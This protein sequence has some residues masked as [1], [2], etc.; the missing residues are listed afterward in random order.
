ML[1][2]KETM[3]H[4]N[5][6]RRPRWSLS[7]ALLGLLGLLSS[8]CVGAIEGSL[9]EEPQR[10]DAQPEIVNPSG[11]VFGTLTAMPP[12]HTVL[13]TYDGVSAY[14][15]GS[16]TST[17]YSCGGTVATGYQYQCVELVQRY[18]KTKWGLRWYGNAK[19]LLDNAPRDATDV[20]A[21]GD[22]A[23]PPVPGDMIVWKTGTWGHVALVVAVRSDA[24]DIIEQNVKGN[25][26]AT[27][28]YGGGW[29]QT[30][31]GNWDVAGWVHAKANTGNAAPAPTP[32][33]P[34]PP[35]PT[36]PTPTPPTPTS[37]HTGAVFGWSFCSQ[38]CPCGE[39]EGDCDGDA[40]CKSGLVCAAD[41]GQQYGAGATVDVCRKPNTPAPPT[42]APTPA[43]APSWS[44]A[45]SSY[46]G[47]QL[48]TCNGSDRYRCEN[49]IPVSE[50]CSAGCQSNPLGTDDVCKGSTPPPAPIN[51]SCAKSS[52]QGQQLWTCSG[53]YRYRCENGVPKADYCAAGCQSNPLGTN[54]ICR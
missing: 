46:Q 38:A 23:H 48:W 43:P 8:G 2:M 50:H 18:F 7:I 47:T 28:G 20:Y 27:L 10:V 54:D 30:R 45:K 1:L 29:V 21:N 26:R 32:P 53:S 22:A 34:T 33:T 14:S 36:P 51:W 11:E 5:A 52:Y 49:G 25:G 16:S 40:E 42:P 6:R 44:C 41:V 31:W 12:C 15:N 13:A 4:R 24:I 19:D 35:T 17:G 9:E 39:G 37:C 3:H